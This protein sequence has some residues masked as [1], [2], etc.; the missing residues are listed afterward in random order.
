MRQVQAFSALM[1]GGQ[2]QKLF[3]DVGS[4][5]KQIENLADPRPADLAQACQLR[6][7]G[8]GSAPKQ[9]FQ[10]QGQGHESSQTRNASVTGRELRVTQ[11][12]MATTR[13]AESPLPSRRRFHGCFPL[14]EYF[15][16]SL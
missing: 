3:L 14:R 6:L 2:E 16:E 11:A 10:A 1:E 5:V 4:K 8:N 13:Q 15:A 12:R 9:P 7:M